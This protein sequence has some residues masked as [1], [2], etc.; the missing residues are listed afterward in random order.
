MC[1]AQ[2]AY[3]HDNETNSHELNDRV[4]VSLWDP[5]F[6]RSFVGPRATAREVLDTVRV[7]VEKGQS[8][9]MIGTNGDG[10]LDQPSVLFGWQGPSEPFLWLL[11]Q[12]HFDV[13]IERRDGKLGRSIFHS[14]ASPSPSKSG[15][16]LMLDA[17]FEEKN[18]STLTNARDTRGDTVLHLASKKWCF[19]KLVSEKLRSN[20]PKDNASY[21]LVQRLLEIG[22]DAHA[23]NHDGYT[24]L[25]LIID[26]IIIQW[27][28]ERDA[29]YHRDYELLWRTTVRSWFAALVNAGYRLREYAETEHSLRPNG[30][31][32]NVY[33]TYKKDWVF[34]AVRRIFL[35]GDGPN[36]V[37]VDLEMVEIEE[38][39]NG[40]SPDIS[41]DESSQETEEPLKVPGSW[42]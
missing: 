21:T 30:L 13:D 22:S 10:G 41:D 9:P 27:R 6:D 37:D 31:L 7:L 29:D 16:R 2:Q 40:E 19:T 23:Q 42:Q 20:D 14:K 25:D 28:I 33:A 1:L 11:R 5:T 18:Y 34:C 8:D 35:Y 38:I 12:D 3:K 32:K 4:K 26:E 17:L 15:P 36:D 39:E 24:P